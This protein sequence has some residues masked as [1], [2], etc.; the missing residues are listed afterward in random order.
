ASARLE[1][2]RR[3]LGAFGE[4]LSQ[5]GAAWDSELR[6]GDEAAAISALDTVDLDEDAV[7]LD[8][9]D[10]AADD[11]ADGELGPRVRA[12]RRGGLGFRCRKERFERERDPLTPAIGPLG[13]ARRVVVLVSTT[14]RRS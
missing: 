4:C 12:L 6:S 13:I 2:L 5:V 14:L 7:V 11:R 9:N 8:P 1:N 3:E 10:L